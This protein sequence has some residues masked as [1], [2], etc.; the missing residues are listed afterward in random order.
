MEMINNS[1]IY[2]HKLIAVLHSH[3]LPG[4]LCADKPP[5]KSKKS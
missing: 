5:L 4:V 1:N 2:T 3:A